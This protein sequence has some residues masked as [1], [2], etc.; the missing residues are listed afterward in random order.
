MNVPTFIL[1]GIGNSDHVHWQMPW[2]SANT[3]FVRVQQRDWENPVCHE[4]MNVLK[5]AVAE[6]EDNNG[7]VSQ[8]PG[9]GG[10]P[11]LGNN[12][13]RIVI[14]VSISA[15]IV[16]GCGNSTQNGKLVWNH[17]S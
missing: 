6:I 10:V 1:P 2:E 17:S 15:K 12:L 16:S 14:D 5:Q 3:G 11:C 8:N 7:L 13:V 4:W 9:Y